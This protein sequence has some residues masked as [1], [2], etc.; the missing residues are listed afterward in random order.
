M[1]GG[2]LQEARRQRGNK[3]KRGGKEGTCW[4]NLFHISPSLL[5]SCSQEREHIPST[6]ERETF[7][8]LPDTLEKDVC[9]REPR[10]ARTGYIP[11]QAGE[12]LLLKKGGRQ[13]DRQAGGRRATE[14]RV[15]TQKRCCDAHYAY[16]RK[17]PKKHGTGTNTVRYSTLSTFVAGIRGFRGKGRRGGGVACV[18]SSEYQQQQ[19]QQRENEGGGRGE[20]GLGWLYQ[21]VEN[22]ESNDSRKSKSLNAQDPRP[23]SARTTITPPFSRQGTRRQLQLRR[24]GGGLSCRDVVD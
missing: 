22:E 18:R 2:L 23:Q 3:G 9:A 8:P 5:L 21:S 4:L 12:A 17:H 6:L 15:A 7:P 10:Q 20:Y 16:S 24:T 13:T 1:S 14:R 19:Q 11:Q